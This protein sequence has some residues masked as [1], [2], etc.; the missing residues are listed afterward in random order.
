MR[1]CCESAAEQRL[2]PGT[3]PRSALPRRQAGEHPALALTGTTS[4]SLARSAILPHSSWW[5]EPVR[6]PPCYR[7]PGRTP[8]LAR[9]RAAVL[10]GSAWRASLGGGPGTA[11][12]EE[13][14]RVAASAPAVRTGLQSPGT[15]H[16]RRLLAAGYDAGRLATCYGYSLLLPP[17][18][19][20]RLEG[21]DEH[22]PGEC[23][24]L[25][26]NTCP[27]APADASNSRH[28]P[29]SVRCNRPSPIAHR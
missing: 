13:A 11:T 24:V 2:G 29:P 9:S 12:A 7:A 25:T 4:P 1:Q 6:R 27:E 5:G 16:W 10:C 19:P 21:S 26:C 17:R 18:V 20:D 22:K 14:A 28:R 15:M 23:I 8:C 3:A